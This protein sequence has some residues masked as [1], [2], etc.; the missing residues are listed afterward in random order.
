[1]RDYESDRKPVIPPKKV[2][3]EDSTP[4]HARNFLDC[5]RSRQPCTCDLETG[6]RSTSATLIAKIAHKTKSYLEWDGKAERFT[7]NPAAN[8]YLSYEYRS[9]YKLP[10]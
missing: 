5:I 1:S 8:K 3:N 2:K 4:L 9:P 6:H 7:N 10:A